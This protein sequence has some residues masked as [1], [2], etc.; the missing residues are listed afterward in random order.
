LKEDLFKES[1]LKEYPPVQWEDLKGDR[2]L[3]HWRVYEYAYSGSGVYL[4]HIIQ[5]RKVWKVGIDSQMRDVLR[6]DQFCVPQLLDPKHPL[7]AFT[8]SFSFTLIKEGLKREYQGPDVIGGALAVGSQCLV[9]QGYWP[10]F[11]CDFLSWSLNL[12]PSRQVTGGVFYRGQEMIAVIYGIG[13]E[14]EEKSLHGVMEA[15]KDKFIWQPPEGRGILVSVDGFVRAQ[16]ESPVSCERSS[17][18]GWKQMGAEEIFQYDVN[19]PSQSIR[20]HGSHN[21]QGT[22]RVYGPLYLWKAY[23]TKGDHTEGLELYDPL[24]LRF[25]SIHKRFMFGNLKS[26]EALIL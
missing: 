6:V 1:V 11:N 18:F 17:E 13:V 5:D 14:N 16:S 7:G 9:G 23:G 22:G 10:R 20:V 2:F 25:F 21:I 24:S 12:G 3:G 26:I 8:G 15:D 19:I 4:G